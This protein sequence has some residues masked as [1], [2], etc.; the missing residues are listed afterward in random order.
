[1]EIK[2]ITCHEVYNY[3]ASLQEYA[4]L[5]YLNSLGHNAEAIHYKPPYLSRH[6]KLNE[7]SNPKF[8]KPLIKQLYLLAKLP[9]R[10]KDLKRKK[11]FDAF[12]KQYI[13]TG[14]T[15]YRNNEDLTSNLPQ[16]DAFICGSDQI[17]NSFFENGKD[18]AFYL[19]FVPDDKLKI[20]YAASFATEDIDENIKPFVKKSV[21][22]LDAISVRETS[23]VKILNNLGIE[24]VTQVLDPIFLLDAAHWVKTFIKPVE[25]NYVLVYDFDSNPQIKEHALKLKK[26]K[27]FK[28]FAMNK[29]INYAD[30]NFSMQGP[31]T[32]LSLIYHSQ[33]I[34][35][36]SFHGLAFAILFEKPFKVVNRNEKINTRMKDLL[37]IFDLS[38][39]LYASDIDI[40]K[41][42]EINYTQ[43][44][45]QTVIQINKSKNFL[46]ETI[47][48]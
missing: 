45:E 11:A 39:L 18:L 13:P 41:S 21:S 36:N 25:G 15:L 23:G 10:I 8:D 43:V 16:A 5:F 26:E 48:E 4:L 24:K 34:L 42:K 3:G 9:G 12:S 14:T 30:K 20:S 44:N 40:K 19:D 37:N 47:K 22:R 6:F 28:I 2:T 38:F 35:T 31:E 29:N 27:G 17:W 1:M 32:F 33:I 46:I 7:V